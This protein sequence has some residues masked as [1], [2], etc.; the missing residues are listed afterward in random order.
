MSR[1]GEFI[2]RLR[3]QFLADR[4]PYTPRKVVNYAEARHIG[5]LFMARQ[6]ED[7]PVINRFVSQLQKDNKQL[8]LLTYLDKISS[9]PYHF[10]Y[11]VFT[12]QHISTLG[13]IKSAEVNQF[14]Y[15]RFDFL[16]CLNTEPFALFEWIMNHSQAKCRVGPY[17]PGQEQGYE[18][19]I[20]LPE[21]ASLGLLS[22][23][24]FVYTKALN[25]N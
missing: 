13:K 8:T 10:R 23:Q 12:R 25:T 5:V 18:I 11:D 24:M 19:M 15:G 3:H 17:F 14:V 2:A 9:N 1:I 16:F 7:F 4:V 20:Q 21:G 6:E 22:E